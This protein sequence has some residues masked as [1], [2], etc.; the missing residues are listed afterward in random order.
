MMTAAH[1]PA[2][3]C[4]HARR[5]GAWLSA[6]LGLALGLAAAGCPPVT[7]PDGTWT[8]PADSRWPQAPAASPDGGPPVA[9]A[10]PAAATGTP[11]AAAAP[12]VPTDDPLDPVA[13]A[14][15]AAEGTPNQGAAPAAG[16]EE[17][18][19]RFTDVATAVGVDFRYTIGDYA[20]DN[21]LESSGSGVAWLDVD[22]DG[23]LDLY[24][25]N[26]R[27]IEDVSD[28]KG[29]VFATARNAL[30]CNLGDG[31]FSDCSRRSG[32]DDG[33]WSMGAA[34][35]DYDG[36]GDQD[37]FVAN[38]GPNRLYRNDGAGQFTDVAVAV[39]LQGPAQL[40]GFVKWS[41]GG[42]WF[43]ADGDG[44]LD[45]MV[46]NFLAFDPYYLHPGKEWEMPDPKEYG[47]QPSML[48]LQGPDG[49]FEEVTERAGLW[50]PDSKCMGITVLDFDADGQLDIFQG[51]DHQP[52]SLWRANGDGTYEDIG[53]RAG[54]AVNDSGLGTGSM[55]GSPGDVDGDGL[56][57][58]LVVDLRH[59]SLYRRTGPLSFED[60]TWS[61]GVGAL[62]DGLG[63]WGAGLH[64][65]DLDGDLDL[66]TTNGVAHILVEQA[67]ALAV[68]D[69]RGHFSDAR[70]GAGAYFQGRRSGR[71]VA[72]GDYDNDGDLDMAIN[73]VDHRAQATLLRNDSLRRGRWVGFE[74][75]A[76][77][78]PSAHGAHLRVQAGGRTFVRTLQP[79]SA[80]LSQNE[81]R[82]HVG[83]GPAAAVESVE[84]RWP[85]GTVQRFGELAAGRYWVLTE[86]KPE[87][88]GASR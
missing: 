44:D 11:A 79:S 47:G 13:A 54:V 63:Q 23:W 57:D 1:T 68:N 85:Q 87:A 60:V 32:L 30:F 86:G 17:T 35:A 56:L 52:N 74:L 46:C 14:A 82:V 43:D 40:N 34:A 75:R 31:T 69:G 72:F 26:G 51:N 84:V 71:A 16:A 42:T 73:H 9:P 62:L 28:P 21:I 24:L 76:R 55:H 48:Y 8:P 5:A 64:D 29:R 7:P 15:R 25:L 78:S 45:L 20:Y 65:L 81:H 19:L 66:F 6:A 61:S 53:F 41:A 33:E 70:A 12:P 83:L 39:G 18:G 10:T 58:L 22:G 77:R 50:R 2:P 36:D 49:R 38:Y 67:P 4:R 88:D 3:P 80:Y 37:V 59:G 27:Y